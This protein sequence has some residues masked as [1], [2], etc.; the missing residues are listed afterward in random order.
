MR[1]INL[2]SFCQAYRSLSFEEFKKYMS[3][4]GFELNRTKEIEDICLFVDALYSELKSC[5]KL[6]G[7]YIGYKIPQIPKEFDLLRL[8]SNFC[9]N[10]EIKSTSETDKIEKQLRRNAYY[11]KAVNS[12]VRVFTFVIDSQKVY[13]LDNE[14]RLLESTL[15]ELVDYICEQNVEKVA[16]LDN[17]F[18]PKQYLVSPLNSTQKFIDG[19]YFLTSAQEEIKENVISLLN[20][21]ETKF[22]LIKGKPGTG[23]TLLTYDIANE[24]IRQGQK[25][26]IV[27]NGILSEG[28]EILKN[29]HGWIL[30]SIKQFYENNTNIIKEND[31]IIFDEAQRTYT[32]QISEILGCIN[33]QSKKCILSF[34]PEQYLSNS[35]N[36]G[37]LIRYLQS[38]GI[39]YKEFKLTD[40]IRTNK[41]L[42]NFILKLFDRNREIGVKNVTFSNVHIQYFSE[43]KDVEKYLLNLQRDGWKVLSYTPSNYYQLPY[44]SY[45]AGFE[46]NAHR[47]IGQ[48]FDKVAVVIDN[49]FY[50]NEEGKLLACQPNGSPYSLLK[51]LYQNVTRARES[52]HIVIYKNSSLLEAC[53][54]IING[55]E[56]PLIAVGV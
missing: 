48:E 27:H 7:F 50:Y 35:E 25:V 28:H 14:G 13:T 4:F 42:S 11:L 31:V 41:E 47:V 32:Y 49:Y 21:G 56:E 15:Y 17:I 54:Q 37:E 30:Y 20:K 16:C 51:M 39:A 8:G 34:D 23:K 38:N 6:D 3:V 10:I 55:R 33:N 2:Q 24:Y 52:L 36:K 26:V 40:K 43:A 44:D 1:S 29:Q 18:A 46:L 5:E 53:L 9:L 19:D 12:E 45:Q 22:I